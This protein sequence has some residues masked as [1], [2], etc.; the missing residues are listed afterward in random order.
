MPGDPRLGR[1]QAE[2]LTGICDDR[3]GRY[4]LSLGSTSQGLPRRELLQHP[5]EGSVF[6]RRDEVAPETWHFSWQ[7]RCWGVSL[8]QNVVSSTSK[9]S[10]LGNKCVVAYAL[11]VVNVLTIYKCSW[12]LLWSAFFPFRDITA[13]P[14]LDTNTSRGSASRDRR[15]ARC[16]IEA[17]RSPARS[18]PPELLSLPWRPISRALADS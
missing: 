17:C 10:R 3:G 2:S 13:I 15:N 4:A 8:Y 16:G 18:N 7:L 6:S 9:T 14:C 12:P 1:G 5:G 11:L